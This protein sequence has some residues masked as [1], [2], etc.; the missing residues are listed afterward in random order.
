MGNGLLLDSHGL[1]M[2]AIKPITSSTVLIPNS[3]RNSGITRYTY[4][5]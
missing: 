5:Y 1:M 3:C 2:A 4:I